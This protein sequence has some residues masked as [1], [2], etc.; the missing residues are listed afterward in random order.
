[1]KGESY[2]VINYYS[3]K[4]ISVVIISCGQYDSRFISLD[5]NRRVKLEKKE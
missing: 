1:M 4:Y 5:K 2:T 3:N